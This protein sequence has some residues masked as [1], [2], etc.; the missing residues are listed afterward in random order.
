M[1]EGL[2]RQQLYDRI[3]ASTKDE[4]ILA[5]MTRLGFWKPNTLMP[6]PSEVLIRKESELRRELNQLLD[7]K[8]RYQNRERML[9]EMRKQ[10]MAAAKAK[11]AET[12]LR[13]E[14]KRKEKAALWAQQKEHQIVYLG[15]DVSQGLNKTVSDTERLTTAGL[16]V[17]HDGVALAAAMGISLGKLRFLSFN[18]KVG[19]VT[20]YKRFYIP[21]KSGGKRLISAPMP[22]L[23]AA[24][25]WILENILYK[26]PNSDAAHGF[27]P[28]RS[29]VTNAVHHVAQDI[30]INID[31]RDFFPTIGYKRV[32]GMFCKLGYSEQVATIL[33]LLCTEP[34]VDQV[35]L[36]GKDYYVA[37]TDRHLPQGAPCSPAITNIICFRLDRRFE[38][39]ARRFNYTYTR[40]ADDM[41]FSAKDTAADDAGKLIW[42]VK[43]VVKEEGFVIHPDKLKVMRKGDKREVTGIVVNDKLSLD[44]DTLRKFRALLHQ[45]S[46]SGLAGKQWGKGNIVSS[47]EGYINYV[48]MV[49]PEAGKQLKDKWLLLLN[50]DDIKAQARASA[51]Q[52][53]IPPATPGNNDTKKEGDKPWWDVV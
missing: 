16:P 1:A 11:R 23:K 53:D 40:Y 36:D 26:V 37:N 19:H 9:M 22:Q 32:K 43:Q 51:V 20:H 44:R 4:V 33:A 21:K 31:L 15:E 2:T 14:E 5:E 42:G 52:S 39:L 25:Y 50:R 13:N 38:G 17:L 45:I 49:K 47:I 18:R 12:K 6:S 35:A 30:V 41:T 34:E 3:R 46:V 7:E 29:I 8:R 27:V 28:G 48:S 24:Q 10:R